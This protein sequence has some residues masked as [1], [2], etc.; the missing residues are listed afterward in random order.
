M[1]AVMIPDEHVP[2]ELRK[3]A[4][5]IV[6]RLD[7][8]PLEAFDRDRDDI[9]KHD[10]LKP[11]IIESIGNNSFHKLARYLHTLGRYLNVPS[12]VKY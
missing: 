12:E 8:T 3:E 4:T 9:S 11:G 7:E 2:Q 10:P 5:V 6:K 1:Q